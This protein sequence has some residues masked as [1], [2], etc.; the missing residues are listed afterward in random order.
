[1]LH[2]LLVTNCVDRISKNSFKQGIESREVVKHT[3]KQE[4]THCKALQLRGA[5]DLVPLML[6]LHC[7]FIH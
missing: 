2:Q 3:Q 5:A 1:M 4:G 7:H 6:F